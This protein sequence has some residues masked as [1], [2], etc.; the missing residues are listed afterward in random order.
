MNID[1]KDI[2]TLSDNNEYIVTSKAKYDNK[3]YYF[4]IDINDN[5]NMKFL[6]EENDKLK[7]VTNY[8]IIEA[9]I[10]LLLEETKKE[11]N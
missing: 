11:L 6:Y 7:E 4:L 1:I 9:I 10:P 3:I 2:I 8:K 5:S